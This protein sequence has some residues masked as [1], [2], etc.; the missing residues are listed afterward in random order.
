MLRRL[1]II[2]FIIVITVLLLILVCEAA[3][4][5]RE[6]VRQTVAIPGHSQVITP[7]IGVV[8][9]AEIN[10]NVD[11]EIEIFGENFLYTNTLPSVMLE[12]NVLSPVHCTTSTLIT[13]VVPWGLE[14][15]RYY[16]I[17][18]ENPDGGVGYL[19]NAISV[20][21][22]ISKWVS[23]GPYGGF[24]KFMV[25]HPQVTSTV[26]AHAEEVGVYR[27]TDAGQTW[28]NV[29]FVPRIGKL[30][31]KPVTGDTLLIGVED[32]LLRSL[33]GGESWQKVITGNVTTLAYGPAPQHLLYAAVGKA[34][35]VSADDGDTWGAPGMGL[36][37]DVWISS[38]AVHPVT[39][40]LAYLSNADG[41]IFRTTDRGDSWE[42]IAIGKFSAGAGVFMINPHSPH[43]MYLSGWDPGAPCH[44]S[45]NGEDWEPMLLPDG[46]KPAFSDIHIP[47]VNDGILFAAREAVYTSSDDGATWYPLIS[48]PDTIWSLELD[49]VTELPLYG[50]GIRGVYRYEDGGITW[51]QVTTGIRGLIPWTLSTV[52]DHPDIVYAGAMEAGGYFSQNAGGEWETDKIFEWDTIQAS[53][54]LSD[55]GKSC[56]AYF[57]GRKNVIYRT[58]NCGEDWTAHAIVPGF[59]GGDIFTIAADPFHTGTLMVGLNS[60]RVHSDGAIFKSTDLGETWVEIDIGFPISEVIDIVFDPKNLGIVYFATGSTFGDQSLSPGIVFKS[61]D[62]GGEWITKANGL[63][64]LPIN[65]LA[66]DPDDSNVLYAALGGYSYSPPEL[67]GGVYKSVDGGDT[68]V[69]TNPEFNTHHIA[70]LVIDP[71]DS[72]TIYAGVIWEGLYQSKDGG[73]NWRRP[74]GPFGNS[75]VYSLASAVSK[76]KRKVV[77]YLGVAA[78][79]FEE[80][81]NETSRN[82]LSGE[83][84]SGAGVYAITLRHVLLDKHLFVPVIFR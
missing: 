74:E 8:T 32:G 30:A 82:T 39:E 60:Y 19:E 11:N 58:K 64:G 47:Q 59:D 77:I 15:D 76:D 3:A 34:V 6:R 29:R 25:M 53:G 33:D 27:S 49:P 55:T 7:T 81:M 2:F 51:T 17:K 52:P 4:M 43:Y 75:S 23:E 9:P 48:Q 72:Q 61:I 12:N 63:N 65:D 66:I 22:V 1:V 44:R 78:G 24:I 46:R 38:I 80:G 16:T 35:R 5:N 18:V 42:E 68:W 10:N 41:Q 13:T 50:G 84:T 45:L 26:F 31:I 73:I 57:G 71:L 36:P 83:V 21:N 14:G 56:E 28:E 40:T 79:S 20:T 54:T 67:L 62:G 70:E 69:Q 37:G